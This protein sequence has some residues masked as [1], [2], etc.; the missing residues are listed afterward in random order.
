LIGRRAIAR[1]A[2]L[3]MLALAPAAGPSAWA[4][5]PLSPD[6]A[7]GAVDV[8]KVVAG[9]SQT[10]VA[11][12]TVFSGSEIFIYGAIKRFSP[13][14]RDEPL[15]IVVTVTGPLQPVV[16]RKKHE[17]LGIWVNGEGVQVDAAPSFYAVAT[18]GPFREVLSWTDDMRYRVG[19]DELVRLIGTPR[20]I[21]YPEEYRQAA[22]RLRQNAGLYLELPGQVRLRDETLFET[23]IRL[24]ANLVEGDYTARIFL[25]R[26]GEVIDV[27]EDDIHVRKVGLERWIYTMAHEQSALYGLGSIVLAL[28]AGWAASTVFRMVLR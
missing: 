8:P 4:Q 7:A 21:E 24:P 27:F 18:T 1:L 2:A 13:P 10:Q 9:L 25:T 3:A 16:V 11:I 20:D 28:F 5:D 19:L 26:G 17:V 15:G 6:P 22:I 14:P 23:R 12:T